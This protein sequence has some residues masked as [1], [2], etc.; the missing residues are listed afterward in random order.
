MEI[1]PLIAN[2]LDG[3]AR[4]I[5]LFVHEHE[6]TIFRLALS[7]LD[8]PAEAEEAAQDALLAALGALDTY[9]GGATFST[10]LYKITL[11]VCLRRL[12]KRRAWERLKNTLYTLTRFFSDP[13]AHPEKT[14]LQNEADA[15]LWHAV[16]TL[17]EKHRLPV[18]FRYYHDLPIA[19]IAQILG[20]HEGTLHS[21]LNTARKRLRQILQVDP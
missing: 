14:L 16:Q 7:I 9:R 20:V 6:E 18:I 3:D 19:D 1:T 8:D 17:D 11:N 21:R 12:Q 4:A 13:P 15:R 10:W 5:E 2:C